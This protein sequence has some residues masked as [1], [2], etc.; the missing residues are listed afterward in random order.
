MNARLVRYEGDTITLA[1]PLE[2][3]RLAVGRECDNEIQLPHVK[4]SKHH[5]VLC[6]V[7][8]GWSIQDCKSTNGVFVN[9][10]SILKAELRHGDRVTI[11][12][13]ELCYETKLPEDEWVP[14]YQLDVS[15]RMHDQ[16]LVQ[17]RPPKPG[18]ASPE[19]P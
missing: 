6:R 5:A 14:C 18:P 10:H 17:P 9:G 19:T 1:F 3:E 11:G 7:K 4:V 15:T 8:D 16:T 12:P 2:G 13:Y